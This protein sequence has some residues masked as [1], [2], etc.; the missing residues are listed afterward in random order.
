MPIIEIEKPAVNQFKR[1]YSLPKKVP[2]IDQKIEEAIKNND[3]DEYNKLIEE[4]GIEGDEFNDDYCFEKN[5][6]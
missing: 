2:E 3:V 6:Q 4:K 5:K 1:K